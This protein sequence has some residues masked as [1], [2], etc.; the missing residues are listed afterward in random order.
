MQKNYVNHSLHD[1][2][3]LNKIFIPIV[4]LFLQLMGAVQRR[5]V[6][7]W[8]KDTYSYIFQGDE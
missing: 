5:T 2:H 1:L 4:G 8:K 7:P 6:E 3:T